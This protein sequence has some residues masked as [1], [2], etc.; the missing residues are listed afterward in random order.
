[1]SFANFSS[2]TISEESAKCQL[3]A[4]VLKRDTNTSKKI[5]SFK[6]SKLLKRRGTVMKCKPI[7]VLSIGSSQSPSKRD[8]YAM[9]SEMKSKVLKGNDSSK[10]D[11][12]RFRKRCRTSSDIDYVFQRPNLKKRPEV[13]QSLA[14]FLDNEGIFQI[15]LKVVLDDYHF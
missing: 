14:S 9:V 5:P 1:M 11:F 4:C 13:E 7:S 8:A 15:N 10:E 3:E 6:A 2:K 12:E